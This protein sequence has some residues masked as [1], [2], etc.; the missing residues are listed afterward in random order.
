MF[1]AHHCP[2]PAHHQH[3]NP[4]FRHPLAELCGPKGGPQAVDDRQE[5]DWPAVQGVRRPA[6]REQDSFTAT[7]LLRPCASGFDNCE[8]SRRPLKQRPPP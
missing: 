7:Q 4:S 8:Q 2:T 1:G 6:L 5:S 3:G